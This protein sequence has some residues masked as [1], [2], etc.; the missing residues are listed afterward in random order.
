MSPS[1]QAAQEIDPVRGDQRPNGVM[2][3]PRRIPADE[4]AYERALAATGLGATEPHSGHGFAGGSVGDG[5]AV[6][7]PVGARTEQSQPDSNL[8]GIGSDAGAG[9]RGMQTG[10]RMS[11][12]G[13]EVFASPASGRGVGNDPVLFPHAGVQQQSSDRAES[14]ALL[15]PSPFPS[16]TSQAVS[17]GES[18]QGF[19]LVGAAAMKWVA[20]LG[21]FVQRRAAYVTQS[22]PGEQTTVVQETLWSPTASQAAAAETE[23]RILQLP[24]PESNLSKKFVSK[25]NKQWLLSEVWLMRINS[26]GWSW[27]GYEGGRLRQV[28]ALMVFKNEILLAGGAVLGRVAVKAEALSKAIQQDFPDMTASKGVMFFNKDVEM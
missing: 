3:G 20:K 6:P 1:G 14:Q 2:P 8:P 16:P 7:G 19:N 26:Y 11:R 25:W 13:H 15:L 22:R 10:R 21:E 17:T 18:S 24:I 23:A 12:V 28:R 5:D 9:D 27:K 4:A